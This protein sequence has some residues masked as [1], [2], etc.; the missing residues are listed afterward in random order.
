MS[1]QE[2][3]TEKVESMQTST[4]HLDALSSYVKKI[5]KFP[6]L[7]S[8]EEFELAKKWHK[9]QDVE[10]R[11]KLLD[12]HQRLVLKIASGYRGYGLPVSDLVAEGNIGMMQAVKRFDPDKGFRFST[13]AMW[14]IKASIKDYVMKNWSL[15]K[16]GTTAAQKKLFFNLKNL[17]HKHRTSED[18]N[19]SSGMVKKI[20]EELD[21]SEKEVRSMHERMKS[22]D[23]SLNTPMSSDG[24][25]EWMDWLIAETNHEEKIV[26][27]QLLQKRKALLEKALSCLN[28]REHS[29]LRYRRLVE[30]PYTLEMCSQEIGVSRER[31]RQIE[32]AAFKKVQ[33][34][35]RRSAPRDQ[36]TTIQ[37]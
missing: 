24:D 8:E 11:Q 31:I 32:Q 23:H 30:P 12:S 9:K 34:E 18:N 28:E 7:S 37:L 6:V 15:V 36:V 35:I 10:A 3:K 14:W 17:A 27:E 26:Q 20:A 13:Y 1:D 25:G 4:R 29:I 5:S 16:V 21:V 33:R 2:E 22:Q 19:M